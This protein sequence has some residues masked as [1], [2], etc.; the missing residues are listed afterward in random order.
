MIAAAH[1]MAGL[2]AGVA[3]LSART[4]GSRVATGL[5]LGGLSHV[6][7]DSIPHSDYGSLPRSTVLASV[8]IEIA[9]TFALGWYLMRSRRLPGVWIAVPAGLAGAMIPDMKFARYFLP[10][11]A[12]SWVR[13]VGE[14]LHGPF[15]A[16]PTAFAVGL[17]F[18]IICTL[19]LFGV[20]LL[21]L[22]RHDLESRVP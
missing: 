20:L 12:G 2:V 5:L 22:R 7:L 16:E 14:R 18:E 1:V 6:V 13:E 8:A 3:A 11:P 9:A 21:L 19:L 4:N 15:H 10:E 17:A